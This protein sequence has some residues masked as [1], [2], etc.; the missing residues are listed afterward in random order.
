MSLHAWMVHPA[1]FDVGDPINP[2]M[3]GQRG[4]VDRRRAEQQWSALVQVYRRLG[5]SVH[6][7]AGTVGLPDQVFIANPVAVLPGR[8]ALASR[9]AHAARAPEVGWAVDWLTARGWRVLPAPVQPLEGYGDLRQIPGSTALLGGYGLRTARAA[10]DHVARVTGRP[11][12]PL[13]LVDPQLYHLDTALSPLAAGVCVWVPEAFDAESRSQI[14]AWFP[15]R[16]AAPYA[17]AVGALAANGHA[18]DGRTY[19]VDAA[20]VRTLEAVRRAGFDAVGVDTSE[21]RRSGGSVFC[22]T[23]MLPEGPQ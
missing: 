3:V 19:V 20:A 7:M 14:A 17:E 10:L 5:V 21:F 4:R 18:P 8:I 1:A 6:V 12:V 9:M 16:I 2:H 11:V 23:Q 15:R 13:R 22:L